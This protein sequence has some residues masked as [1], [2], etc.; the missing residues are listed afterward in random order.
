M[1]RILRSTL[2]VL[3]SLA[4]LLC[5]LPA[6]LL[7]TAAKESAETKTV[8][9]SSPAIPATVGETV[10]LGA[11]AVMFSETETAAAG[12][13]SWSSPEVMVRNGTVTA[14]ARGVYPL[15]AS[16]NGRSRTVYLVVKDPS[17]SE[18]V[19]YEEEFD[20]VSSFEDLGYTVV[21]KTNESCKIALKDGKLVLSAQSHANNYIRVLLPDFLGDFADYRIETVAAM[22]AAE[23]AT[24]WMSFMFRI[25]N[26]NYPYYQAAVR[27]NATAANGTE[28]AYRNPSNNW[29][30]QY[31]AAYSEAVTDKAFR[32]YAVESYGN[33]I[34]TELN[35][36]LLSI[37]PEASITA[38]GKIGLQ[39]RGCEMSLDSVRITLQLTPP[40]GS[41]R[42]MAEVEDPESDVI[43][44]PSVIARISNA[45][46]LGALE[47]ALK[48]DGAVLP[49]VATFPVSASL[50]AKIGT[51]TLSLEEILTL[52][53]KRIIPAFTVN[54]PN[55]VAPLTAWLEEH[56]VFDVFLISSN[57]SILKSA[58]DAYPLCRAVL[59]FAGKLNKTESSDPELL[60]SKVRE[61]ANRCGARICLLPNSIVN[62]D[63]VD[64][65]QR[66]LMTVWT[67]T[68]ETTAGRVGSI[69]SGVNG[70][71]ASDFT[72]LADAFT[73]YFEPSTVVRPSGVVGHRGVPS[74]A[75][76]NTVEG[77]ML[78]YEL[79]VTAI[80]NDVYLTKDGV[81]IVMH[82]GTVDR[83][84]NGTG[85]VESFTYEEL[86]A[87]SVDAVNGI[88]PVPIPTLEDYYKAFKGLDVCFFVEV[89]SSNTA[90]CKKIADLTKEYGMMNQVSVIS[91]GTGILDEMKRVCPELSVGYLTGSPATN[92]E[93]PTVAVE[94]ILKTVQTYDST[95]NPSYGGVGP[96]LIRAA[97][98][99]GITFWPWT[100]NDR[101]AFDD[102]FFYGT[103]G[104]TTNFAQ[105]V[106]DCVRRVETDKTVYTAP[107]AGTI[108]I[109]VTATSYDR[110]TVP[111]TD[112]TLVLLEGDGIFTYENA[113]L[114]ASGNGKATL[115]FS[116][117]CTSPNGQT[118]YVCTAPFTVEVGPVTE[119]P[120]TTDPSV[121]TAEPSVTATEPSVTTTEPSVTAEEPPVT[122]ESGSTTEPI[123][124][125][126]PTVTVGPF[127]TSP[128]EPFGTEEPTVTTPDPTVTADPTVTV[129]S[130]SATDTERGTDE[131]TGGCRSTLPLP[132]LFPLSLLVFAALP[133]FRKREGN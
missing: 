94:R 95:Y 75:P 7:P 74:L 98:H 97:N 120:V 59:D 34:R 21:E 43:L 82:D 9:H 30:V 26:D 108:P 119:P 129:G 83:T 31:T 100:V 73:R 72:A 53:D 90:I 92:E 4:L 109:T 127:V 46:E 5:A 88:G 118:Y 91:F 93:R 16:V 103:N 79:G 36:E 56:S 45:E 104:I 40:E 133:C 76:E 44:P 29:D 51:R 18:Y 102:H 130:S 132:A 17:E 124:T 49:A 38:P 101:A 68:P 23:S 112:G 71:L 123:V 131:E 19:L 126:E 115:M 67:A 65:L 42:Y 64:R 69:V 35:G 10:D 22:T 96:N 28:I 111:R 110:E 122:A 66:L 121:T 85:K 105:Y 107:Q 106:S 78:A 99:R 57:E 27:G 55:T 12:T 20:G 89:K 54:D 87:F 14:P 62:A 13:V 80:E 6:G 113:T 77:S 60:I 81:V 33:A 3:L 114:R 41:N 116:V 39:V 125:V 117:P 86:K 48:T 32:T 24:R 61:T 1:R 2:P 25:Q 11:Y 37:A 47:T 128:G 15:T 70:I 50:N 52:L 58:R 84:T 8:T 63:T